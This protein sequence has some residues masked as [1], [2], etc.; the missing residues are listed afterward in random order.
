VTSSSVSQHP[1]EQFWALLEDLREYPPGVVPLPEKIR[2][3]AFF[4]AGPGLYIDD[5]DDVLPPFP[6][7]GVMFVGHNLDAVGPYLRRL[8]SGLPHGGPV[9]PMR[10]WANLYRLLDGAG[11]DR[12][13]CFFTN[14]YVGLKA[15]D[16]PTGPFL[17][18]RNPEFTAWCRRFLEEQIAVMRPVVIATLG[19]PAARFMATIAPTNLAS[20]ESPKLP[21]MQVYEASIAGHGAAAVPLVHPSGYHSSLPSRRYAGLERLPAEAA[22]LAAAAGVTS[23]I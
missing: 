18:A 1:V 9:K 23:R 7:G 21:A 2:G 15:G 8:E 3:T 10:T 20:W 14:A 12:R 17:G 11:V 6:F 13:K 4:S 16:D 19:A 5:V 22:L